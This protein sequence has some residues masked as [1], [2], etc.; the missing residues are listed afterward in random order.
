MGRP[1]KIQKNNAMAGIFYDNTNQGTVAQSA[2]LDAGYPPFAAPTSMDVATVVKPTPGTSPLPFTGVVGGDYSLSTPT[3]SYPVVKCQVNIKL[4][5]GSGAGAH[6]GRILRQK[7][8]RKFM[9]VDGTTIQDEDCVVGATYQILSIAGTDWTQWGAPAG[10]QVGTI[11]TCTGIGTLGNGTALLVGTCVLSNTGTPTAGNM[12]ISVSIADS[13]PTYLSKLT[14][15]FAQDFNGGETGG[16]ANTGNV[17]NDTQVV[18]NIEYAANF[19]VDGEQFTKS[20]ADVATWTG[21]QQN[22]N[23][24]LTMAEVEKFT[25]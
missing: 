11:F 13:T 12:A 17:W 5:S 25:S 8:S 10:F 19:F 3:T 7:G 21:T 4:P 20:G 23:G 22:S 24:T 15:K 9:V 14:N 2:L 1:L 6:D 16:S 18:N